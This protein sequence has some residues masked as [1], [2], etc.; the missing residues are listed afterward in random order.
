MMAVIIK[1]L[2]A[3]IRAIGNID[4]AVFIDRDASGIFK[5]SIARSNTP[6]CHLKLAIKIK[7]LD[8][9]IVAITNID[10]LFLVDRNPAWMLKL[11]VSRSVDAKRSDLCR[12]VKDEDP[13][14]V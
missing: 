13:V 5:A 2:D 11:S 8:A 4:K 9:T 3:M 1:D 14:V 7:D 6:K 10:P 12:A